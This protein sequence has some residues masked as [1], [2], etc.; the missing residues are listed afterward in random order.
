M[1]LG[2]KVKDPLK[3]EIRYLLLNI[4]LSHKKTGI[5]IVDL[6]KMTGRKNHSLRHHLDILEKKRL[7]YSK[8][9]THQLY[10]Y[11][12]SGIPKHTSI[13]HPLE[14]EIRSKML[15]TIL[16]NNGKGIHIGALYKKL[17]VSRNYTLRCLKVLKYFE[18]IDL[19]QGSYN[20]YCHSTKRSENLIDYVNNKISL[21]RSIKEEEGILTKDIID[22]LDASGIDYFKLCVYSRKRGHDTVYY[23]TPFVE[24]ILE[25]H[26]A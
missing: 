21:F 15:E 17:G 11:P 25:K 19:D 3:H 22:K 10:Y 23:L 16:N 1:V 12:D 26:E 9:Y 6:S 13:G 4:I 8:R 18:L 20:T 2:E 14:N 24:H 5:R 7:V